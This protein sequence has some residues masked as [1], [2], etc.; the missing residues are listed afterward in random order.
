MIQQRQYK[1]S[2]MPN[3]SIEQL[4]SEARF[5]PNPNQESAIRHLDGPLYLPAG[6][7]SGKTRVL[8]WRTL[9]L[10][11]FHDVKPEEMLLT[12][13]TEKASLQLR[14]GLRALLGQ[15]TYHTGHPYDLANMY[16]GTMHSLCQR[17]LTDRRFTVHGGRRHAPLLMD[18]LGQYL[19]LYKNSQWKKL[20]EGLP[21]ANEVINGIVNAGSNSRHKAVTNCINVFN[22]LSEE[23]LSAD[24]IRQAA[25]DSDLQTLA[26]LYEGY[27]QMLQDN[28]RLPRTDFALLQQKA[29]KLLEESENGERVFRHVIVDEYQDTNTIQEKLYFKLAASTR[30]L[31]VVGDDDQALYRF[32]GATVEN[33]VEFPG[34]CQEHYGVIPTK[35]PLST[36]YR[37]RKRIVQFYT[38][39]IAHPTCNW[40]KPGPRKGFFRVT[41]KN[42]QASSQD[43]GPAVIASSP[44]KPD[45]VCAEIA[46][47][48][49]QIIQSGKV[50][51]PNQIAFLY[52]SLKS[53]QVKRMIQ[54]LVDRGLKVYTPRAGTFLQVEE[55]K[56]V[57]GLFLHIFG[58]PERGEWGG[59]DYQAYYDWIDEIYARGEGMIA[60]DRHLRQFIQ[61]RYG[62]IAVATA[63]YQA[64]KANADRR[65]WSL[66]TPYDPARMQLVLSAGLSERARRSLNSRF[67]REMIANRERPV[68]IRYVINRCSSLDWN[69]LDLF[70]RLCGFDRL[71]AMFDQAEDGVLDQDEGP[72]CNLS[73]ISKYLARFLDEYATILT[74]EF[75]ADSFVHTFFSS[76]LYA[77]YRRG[78]A[79][80]EDAEDPF[81]KGR[82]PFL[83]IHQAKGLEFPVVV[84]GNLDKRDKVQEV[85]QLVQPV[86]TREGEPLNLMPR[87]DAMRMFYVALS[88]AQN[89]LILPHFQGS[90]QSLY[91][92]FHDMLDGAIPASR[93]MILHRYRRQKS[94]S[95]TC[96]RIILIPVITCYIRAAPGNT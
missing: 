52:P 96:P 75:L 49:V 41:D 79:E 18:E 39:F 4:W 61:D 54:A 87:F 85:E 71:R 6:P 35:I 33:F 65:G 50:E 92:P 62:D 45:R 58:Q 42:I 24:G 28:P 30:N 31:C 74:G 44:G 17:M 46:D 82:I 16:V 43:E 94:N 9:N 1:V 78:E 3:L 47:L 10:I 34:R 27:C 36:N 48:V 69:V 8:L 70:Y 57:F 55:S 5:S 88:R 80:Y 23:C 29:L 93:S 59:R 81:P 64:M 56:D 21:N 63:D 84:L 90:G 91:P 19:F 53:V 86:L 51:N 32:R 15:V 76:Y 7:G 66:D 95:M 77:L 11:V 73:L 60:N 2:E 13:F 25:P 22:R 72:I 83:T 38:H 89:L 26:E 20:T 68:P 37:S 67:L 12:T 14:E 40:A